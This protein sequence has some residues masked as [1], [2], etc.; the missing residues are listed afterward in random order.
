MKGYRSCRRRSSGKLAVRAH[1]EELRRA[2]APL[3]EAFRGWEQC[4]VSSFELSDLIHDFHQGPARELYAR[5]A[6][7]GRGNLTMASAVARGVLGR[8]D[9]PPRCSN[10]S[11][12]MSSC[13]RRCGEDDEAGGI[14]ALAQDG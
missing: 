9:V 12:V 6:L 8:R 2:L 10:T 3:A 7:R 11:A 4:R 5:Y 14:S 1:E 13:A